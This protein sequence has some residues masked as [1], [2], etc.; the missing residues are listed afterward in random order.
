MN[1]IFFFQQILV[2]V[3]KFTEFLENLRDPEVS[4]IISRSPFPEKVFITTISRVFKKIKE[5]IW[6]R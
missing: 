4:S 3:A 6:L 5:S 2:I 1:S